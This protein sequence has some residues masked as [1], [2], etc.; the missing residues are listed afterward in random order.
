MSTT[1][2]N[3]SHSSPISNFCLKGLLEKEKLTGLNF[4]DWLRNLR[5]VLRMEGKIQSIE[6]PLPEAPAPRATQA[7]RDHYESRL[8]ESNE[9]ACLMLATM[10][11]ELQKG[12]ESLGAF[13][14]LVQLKDMF[15]QQAKQERFETVKTLA[16]CKMAQGSSV[17]VHVLKMKGYV[18]QLERLGFPIGQELA[19]DFILN[20]LT[21][22]YDSFVLNYNMNSMEKSIME[23]HGMLKTAESNIAKAKPAAAAVLAIREGGVKK[24]KANAFKGKGKG[25]GTPNSFSKPKGAASTS[26]IPQSQNTKEATCFHCGEKGHWRRSCPTYMKGLEDLKAKGI[27]KPSGMFMI[28]LNNTSISNSWVL[29]TGC[30]THICTNVQGLQ[31]SRRLR[32]G[33]LDLIMGNKN[34][35]SVDMIGDY[36]LYFDSGLCIVLLDVCYSAAMARNIIS[37]NALYED[38]F[39]FL[40]DNGNISVYKNEVFYF[41]ASPCR[42]ILETTIKLKESSIYNVDTSENG[43]D[44]TYL[45]HCRLGHINKKRIAKLQLDGILESFD[46][47]SY[48]QCE[49]CLLGKM[50]KAP[51]TGNCER[52]KDL[53]ELVHTDV[54]GPFR[55]ATRHGERYFVTFTDDFSRYGYIYLMKHKSETFSMF[56]AYQNEVQNQ[57]DKRIKILRS[58][59]GGEY[60]SQEFCDHLRDC[61]IISQLSPPRTPQHNG[62]SERRNRTLLDMVRSMMSR[63]TLP[64]SFWGYALETA[65]KV[66]NLI[67]TKKVSKTPSEIWNGKSH[68]LTYLRVWGCECYV[69]CDAQDKLEPRSEKCLFIGYPGDSFGYL[70]YNP[71]ENKVFVSR[72]A[73]FLEKDLIS[74]RDSGSRIDLEEIQE[75]SDM[76][77]DIGTSSSQRMVAPVLDRVPDIGT[78]SQQAV[79]PAVVGEAIPQPLPTRRSDRVRHEPERYGLNISESC[80][81]QLDSDEPTSYQEA[82]AGPESAKWQEAMESEI[83]SMHDNQVWNLIDH[84]P[85]LKTIGCKWVFKKKID[86]DGN[87]HT[88]KARLVAKGYTQTHGVDYDETFSPVA[89]LKS[90]RILIA[91]AAFYD[92]EIWQM[93]VKTAFLNGKLTEDVFMAQP[94]GFIH[95]KYPRSVCKLQ[96]SIYGL[97]QASRSWNL[98]FDEKIKSFGFD[99]SED[100]PCVYV[101]SSDNV[102][103]FL[104]LYVDDILLIGNDIPTLKDVKAWLGKCFAMKDMGD[105]AYILG[106]KIYR[107]RSKRL[108]GLSQST[109]IDKI[110][111]KFSMHD[112]KKGCVPMTPGMALSKSQC[113]TSD[114]EIAN[115]SRIPYASAIG[116]IMYAMICTR[117]DVAYALSMTSRYQAKPG[118]AHWTAVKNILKYLRRTKEM[119]LVYG[120]KDGLSVQGYSDASFQS[121]RDNCSSQSGFVFVLNGGAVTWRSSKQSTIADSTTESE[122]IAVNEAAKEAMWIRKFIGDLGVVPTIN[123]PVEIFCDNVSAVV[124]AQEPRSQ[125]RTRH[126]LRKYHYVRQVVADRDIVINRVDT[127]ENLADPFTK[128]LGQT[129]HDAH[130]RSIGIRVISDIV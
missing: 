53:L 37:F 81:A 19:T 41:K 18:D 88:F 94:E 16:S 52:G 49:S 101:R 72:R 39:N 98:C 76:E 97:K 9:V 36:K 89:M 129:K 111:K 10:I 95:P 78:S 68:T 32:N 64:I 103:T 23:L 112:S 119:F 130:T 40:F 87:V 71:K 35:A 123:D 122:Y 104:V 117:P 22:S 126:I 44:K 114:M 74:K 113:A 92:Y 24:K 73:V 62:V 13:T 102:V 27:A 80:D 77:I 55:S 90:I 121:D 100:E 15:Q 42:G 43:L 17:S 84:T 26:K 11:P 2:N 50:T 118:E 51:F 47:T 20:S 33:E 48:D 21:S 7:L 91:I 85:G 109:Y 65:A 63:A 115:M 34:V 106:I 110:L 69:R 8:K 12:M 1:T 67:P 31:R 61:G 128:P 6:V 38:G 75:P 30:G 60:L 86:M 107:D 66:L 99:R 57:L 127:N 29:D 105:A 3:T 4:I 54:C 125:K 96:K 28:E 79:E 83:Q 108:I 116:S 120:G 45:W 25:K 5:I 56:K 46:I 59:R 14:M 93:D 124:L 82:M 58:D 70:F